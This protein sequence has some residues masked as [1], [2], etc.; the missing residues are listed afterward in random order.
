[1][2]LEIVLPMGAAHILGYS[3]QHLRNLHENG[4]TSHLAH[5]VSCSSY[6]YKYRELLVFKRQVLMDRDLAA[7]VEFWRPSDED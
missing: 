2:T 6:Y 5:R 7:C 1:M 4:V 3:L